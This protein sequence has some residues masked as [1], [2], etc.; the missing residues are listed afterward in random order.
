MKRNKYMN[1]IMKFTQDQ[2][3]SV[4]KVLYYNKY[5][6]MTSQDEYEK[7]QFISVKIV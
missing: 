6:K 4:Q 3:R 5:E 7:I 1:S 2:R